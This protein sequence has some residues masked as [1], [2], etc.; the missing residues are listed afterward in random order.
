[1]V[2]HNG[3]PNQN[4]RDKARYA[5]GVTVRPRRDNRQ[6]CSAKNMAVSIAKSEA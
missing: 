2:C 3:K 6:P 4:A 5:V 1:M